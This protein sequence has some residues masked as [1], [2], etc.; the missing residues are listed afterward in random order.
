MPRYK[1]KRSGQVW[2]GHLARELVG[3][4][5]TR[6]QTDRIAFCQNPGPTVERSR[7]RAK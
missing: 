7:S 5:S 4:E 3:G 1:L 6:G 2:P